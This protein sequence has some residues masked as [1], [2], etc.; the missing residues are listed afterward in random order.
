MLNS[1]CFNSHVVFFVKD[2]ARLH[3]FSFSNWQFL[4]LLSIVLQETAKMCNFISFIF[5]ES[6]FFIFCCSCVPKIESTNI[7][8]NT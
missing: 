3:S 6:Q 1:N 5:T 7:F 2:F 4:I 8:Y